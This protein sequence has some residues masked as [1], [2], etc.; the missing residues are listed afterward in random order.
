MGH[1]PFP[2][3]I[4]LCLPC[5]S[6][7]SCKKS[8]IVTPSYTFLSIVSISDFFAQFSCSYSSHKRFHIFIQFLAS[9]PG[10]GQ[11]KVYQK[12]SPKLRPTIVIVK[13]FASLFSKVHLELEVWWQTSQYICCAALSLKVK[14]GT[15]VPPSF[16]PSP[17]LPS[18][19][20]VAVVTSLN[21]SGGYIAGLPGAPFISLICVKDAPWNCV[22]HSVQLAPLAPWSCRSNC[23]Q[24]T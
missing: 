5:L 19:T 11:F 13:I 15:S 6:T 7:T 23:R 3:N 9:H 17:P 18:P 20:T 1:I 12:S 10:E 21:T 8:S 24:G 16:L 22:V 14:E 4:I 2:F